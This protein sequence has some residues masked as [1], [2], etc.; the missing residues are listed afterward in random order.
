MKRQEIC[1]DGLQTP[2]IST[3]QS[4]QKIFSVF[5][6]ICP[7]AK[8][9]HQISATISRLFKRALSLEQVHESV[10]GPGAMRE[11]VEKA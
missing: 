7:P 8:P 10:E 4:T 11:T 9:C 3:P 1:S 5:P 2:P 6:G